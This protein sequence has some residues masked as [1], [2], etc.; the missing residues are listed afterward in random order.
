MRTTREGSCHCGAVRYE[1]DIDLT[2]GTFRCNCSICRKSR[3]WLAVVSAPDLRVLDGRDALAEYRVGAHRITHC[4]CRRCGI[5][6]FGRLGEPDSDEGM[7][8][9]N[10]ATL[11]DTDDAE[12]ATVSIGYVNG[13][14]DDFE[15]A[16]AE[17]RH[18]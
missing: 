3:S 17:T 14:D 8:A 15:A 5:R 9:V 12:L 2:A 6:P 11:D 1:T 13:G 18:L 7:W 10:V 4:F 16:P